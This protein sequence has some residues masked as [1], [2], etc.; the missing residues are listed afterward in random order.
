[1]DENFLKPD[2]K[3]EKYISERLLEVSDEEKRRALK[4]LLQKTMIPFY[5]HTKE[6]YGELEKRLYEG[7]SNETGAYEII[8]GI[9]RRG[10]VDITEEAMVPMN[11]DDLNEMVVDVEEMLDELAQGRN[12]T[13]MKIFVQGDYPLIKKIESERRL[14]QSLIVTERGEYHAKVKLQKNDSY[15]QKMAE[16]YAMFENNGIGWRTVCM[17]YLDKFFDVKIVSTDCPKEEQILRM[18]TDF[19][20]YAPYVYYDI[21]P[22]WNLRMKEEKTGTYPDFALDR[23]HYEHCIFRSRLAEDREYLVADTTA[24]LWNVFRQDGDLHIV[25][26]EEKDRK[27]KLVEFGYDAK[28]KQY[29]YPIFGNAVEMKER[30]R[31]IHTIA[32]VKAFLK[33]MQCKDLELVDV[34]FVD[35]R[36]IQSINTYSMDA[37]LQDEIRLGNTGKTL[38]CIFRP[39]RRDNYLNYDILSYLV[40]RLQWKLPEFDCIGEME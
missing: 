33:S 11:Y 30:E 4:E 19:E 32:E 12:Y 24:H 37:F 5:E 38:K 14:F 3:F 7:K 16:L 13:I 9:E 23:I 21:I 36:Q 31:L 10:K 25:C 8:T 39:M 15:I 28:Q 40:S 29:E 22:M 20:E 27:W 34:Q 6:S 2:F 17:P 35:Q 1:M 18:Q 26:D